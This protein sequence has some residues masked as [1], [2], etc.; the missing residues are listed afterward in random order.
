[1]LLKNLGAGVSRNVGIK[2]SKGKFILFI[3]ADDTWEPHK[4]KY[5]INKMMK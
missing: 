4:I 1:L 5:Q 3:D 2:K